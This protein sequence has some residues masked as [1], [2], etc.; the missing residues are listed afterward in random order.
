MVDTIKLPGVRG[1]VESF[2]I[3]R[4]YR[5][6]HRSRPG[7]T[8]RHDYTLGCIITLHGIVAIYA[9]AAT[10]RRP[11]YLSLRALGAGRVYCLVRRGPKAELSERGMSAL[12]TRFARAVAGEVSDG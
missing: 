8:E 1:E 12:A 5:L 10:E 6:A 3:E 4:S 9:E 2:A 7:V 11:A